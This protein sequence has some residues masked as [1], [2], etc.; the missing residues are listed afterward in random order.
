M[1][2]TGSSSV[3]KLNKVL[4][5]LQNKSSPALSAVE[6]M[7][8]RLCRN[9]RIDKRPDFDAPVFGEID[10]PDA[11]NLLLVRSC[12]VGRRLKLILDT[13]VLSRR[14]TDPMPKFLTPALV[15]LAL[16]EFAHHVDEAKLQAVFGKLLYAFLLKMWTPLRYAEE[17]LSHLNTYCAGLQDLARD[18]ATAP[19]KDA[20]SIALAV[21][22]QLKR[23]DSNLSR[24]EVFV[25]TK[26]NQPPQSQITQLLELRSKFMRA[27]L[28]E[29]DYRDQKSGLLDKL[30]EF[31]TQQ[32]RPT[33]TKRGKNFT[34]SH[35]FISFFF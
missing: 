4:S 30:V 16:P 5:W 35:F 3:E 9:F 21:L 22:E 26:H 13:V 6:S 10:A 23:L 17:L 34:I 33:G 28:K 14:S 31:N 25:L 18:T 20:N 32:F 27:E 7:V 24:I 12:R 11:T 19:P 1:S 2:S 8:L 15:S 29:D